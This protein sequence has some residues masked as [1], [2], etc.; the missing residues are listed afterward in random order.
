VTDE[1]RELLEECREIFH[2]EFT[3]ALIQLEGY[4]GDVSLAVTRIMQRIDAV[5]DESG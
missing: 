4:I 2:E 1:Q 3:P 5:L